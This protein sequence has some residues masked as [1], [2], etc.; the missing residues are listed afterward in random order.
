MA[1]W[2]TVRIAAMSSDVTPALVEEWAV[3]LESAH[4]MVVDRETEEA[5]IRSFFRH[6]GILLQPNPMKGA[7]RQFAGIA[8][9]RLRGVISHELNRLQRE[10]PDG[11]S[12]VGTGVNVWE[13]PGMRTL[14]GT[15]QINVKKASD[16]P[17]AI[18][19]DDPS[20]SPSVEGKANPSTN[21]SGNP[22]DTSTS[23]YSSN[24]ESP[25]KRGTRIPDDFT[26]NQ[27][28]VAWALEHAPAVDGRRATDMFVNHWQAASGRTA[29]KLDW[30]KA[31]KNW[32]LSDQQ[33]AEERGWK[34]SETKNRRTFNDDDE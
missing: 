19:S 24:E 6:D 17:S 32:L 2:R 25:R 21:P 30:V 1:D 11:F 15:P 13:L 26:V 8:S 27:D 9:G 22:S 5:L 33:R 28:M 16:Y 23:T 4:F 7:I 14:L 31:W 3:E 34:P 18:P 12:K 20:V 29:T 10:N